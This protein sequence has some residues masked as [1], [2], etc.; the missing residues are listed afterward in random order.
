MLCL[1]Q[2]NIVLGRF[3]VGSRSKEVNASYTDALYKNDTYNNT[4]KPMTNDICFVVISDLRDEIMSK[5][6]MLS[7]TEKFETNIVCV[8]IIPTRGVLCTIEIFFC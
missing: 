3:R 2:G 5:L 7:Y 6:N 1:M 8:H 4:G